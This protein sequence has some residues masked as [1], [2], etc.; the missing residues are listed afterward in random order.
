[1]FLNAT[2]DI[3]SYIDIVNA[4]GAGVVNPAAFYTKQLLDTIRLDG[5][6]YVYFRLAD[7]SPIGK[8]PTN[9]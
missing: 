2:A 3:N 5:S 6:D 1:M 4:A 8:K 9:S 7:T